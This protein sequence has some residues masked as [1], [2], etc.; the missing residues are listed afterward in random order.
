MERMRPRKWAVGLV[1]AALLV[2]ATAKADTSGLVAAYGFEEASGT[3]VLDGSGNA[4]TGTLAGPTRSASGRFGAALSFDGVNDVVNVP[5]ATSLD[6]TTALTLEA[7]VNPTAA[8][9]WRTVILKEQPA[10]MAYG[11]YANTD[12]NRPSA[13]AYTSAEYGPAPVATGAWTHLAATYD[14]AALRLYVNGTQVSSRSLSGAITISSGALRIGGNAIW[15]EYFAGRIDEVRIYRRT[16]APAEVQADMNQPVAGTDTTPPSTPAGVTASVVSFNR[17][18]VRW[19]ASTD[20]TGVTAYRVYR[21]TTSGFTPSAANLLTTVAMPGWNELISAPGTYYYRIVAVDRAANASAP[22]AEASVTVASDTA[23]PVVEITSPDAG[24]TV[25]GKPKLYVTGTDDRGIA[26]WKLKIDDGA[27]QTT[28]VIGG[29]ITWNAWLLPNGPHTVIVQAVDD[30]GNVGSSA[31]RTYTVDNGEP[32]T[33]S[34]TGPADGG[35]VHG[36]VTLTADAVSGFGVTSVAFTAGP[37][38]GGGST[39]GSDRD[40][41][42]ETTWDTT[43]WGNGTY[44]VTA[45]LDDA[46]VGDVWF[47]AP[48]YL[49]VAN[50]PGA[51]GAVTA[52]VD[53]DDVHLTWSAPADGTTSATTYRV[54]RSTTAGFTPSTANRIATVTTTSYDDLNLAAG[55]YRYKVVAVDAGSRV[56]PPSDEATASVAAD[57]TPPTVAILTACGAAVHDHAPLGATAADERALASVQFKLDGQDLGAP[58]TTAPYAVDWDTRQTTNGSHT[59]TAVARDAAGNATTSAPCAFTVD[60]PVVQPPSQLVAAYGFEEASGTSASDASGHGYTGTIS[61]ATR[62]AA[63]RFGRALSFDGI[64]DLVDVAHNSAFDLGAA[65][66]LEAWVRPSVVASWRTV[67]MEQRGN[68]MLY[69]LYASTDTDRPSGHVFTSG[70]LDTRG[71]AKLAVNVWT[72][73]AVTYDGSVLRLYVNGAEASSRVVG[74]SLPASD[75]P[76]TIGGNHLWPEWFKGIIDEVRVYGRSLTAAEIQA[77]RDRAVG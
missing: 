70:E 22:S 77:D 23:P 67:L 50:G 75:G 33:V 15:G 46:L 56:G 72:H 43:Q 71:P 28:P 39:V 10:G 53:Q 20:D 47:S 25:I 65:M 21:S 44:K 61:G 51:P 36:S 14:G 8:T 11:L 3:A 64:N 30:A 16:L 26:G 60:N 69:A 59:V 4:N 27:A 35:T 19:S 31:P 1:A 54:H 49:T 6:A 9:N 37:V 13:H 7:W 17:A 62:T 5:D 48:I 38:T 41:P 76:L 29:A 12:T 68:G 57:T 42:Y 52:G 63:G 34:I 55:A 58:L 24:A 18:D 66:T 74:G 73:L 32:T 40:A 45:E 2:P